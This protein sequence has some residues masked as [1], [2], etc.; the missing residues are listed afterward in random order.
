MKRFQAKPDSFLKRKSSLGDLLGLFVTYWKYHNSKYL[1]IG[2]KEA[3][4]LQIHR[5]LACSHVADHQLLFLESIHSE[6]EESSL[7]QKLA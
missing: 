4:P 5:T 6:D 7:K 3:A 1:E 2:N